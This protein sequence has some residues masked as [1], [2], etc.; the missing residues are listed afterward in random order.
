MVVRCSRRL[1]SSMQTTCVATDRYL[2]LLTAAD[3]ES[4]A[5]ASGADLSRPRLAVD[6]D[7]LTRAL[8]ADDTY[9]ALF[10]PDAPVTGVSPTLVFA[11][12]VHRGGN[13][14]ATANYVPERVGTRVM[15]PVFDNARLASYAA[16]PEHR[17]FVVELLGSFTKVLS[18]PRWERRAGRWRKRRFSE[19]DP[20]DMAR[21]VVETPA[22]ERAGVYRRLGDL[23]LFLTGVFPDHAARQTL[24]GVE[25][26]RLLR[27]IPRRL[28]PDVIT[29]LERVDGLGPLM[30]TLGP[31]WYRLAARNVVVPRLGEHLDAVADEFDLIRRFMVFLADRY[32]FGRRERLFPWRP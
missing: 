3:L 6:P 22:P 30:T 26:E 14:I 24:T 8:G 7:A 9:R 18:G 13:E 11:I 31:R 4:L 1:P 32:L 27:S 10:G 23:A 12:V 5:T 20:V 28:R 16:S 29:E 2:E 25:I 17:L 19:L 15:V 21:L